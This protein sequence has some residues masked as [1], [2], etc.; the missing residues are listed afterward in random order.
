MKDF[1]PIE[2]RFRQERYSVDEGDKESE[3]DSDASGDDLQDED[4]K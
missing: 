3:S 4:K 1:K 2:T